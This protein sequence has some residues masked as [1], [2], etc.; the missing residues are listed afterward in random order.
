MKIIT[1]GVGFR[2]AK[3]LK[4]SSKRLKKK[5]IFRPK[6]GTFFPYGKTEV[7]KRKHF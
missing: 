5:S 1:L 6:I 3:W 4:N 2:V 7:E